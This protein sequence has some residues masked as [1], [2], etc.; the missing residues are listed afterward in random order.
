MYA[1]PARLQQVLWNLIKNAVKFT[2]RGGRIAIRSHHNA[3]GRITI[4]VSDTGIGIESHTL[5]VIFNAFEQGGSA[6]TRRF[7]G[8]GLGLAIS[9]KLIESH[10]G[11]STA[12]SEGKDR[13]ATFTISLPLG[14]R[15]PAPRAQ[16]PDPEPTNSAA[17]GTRILLVEDHLST[18]QVMARL[19]KALHFEVTVAHSVTTALQCAAQETFDLLISDLGL[20][21]AS[22]YDL[23]RQIQE[24][25][26]L[27]GIAL[28]GYGMEEDIKKSEEAGFSEHLIKPVD[29]QHLEAAIHRL[30]P[31]N[32]KAEPVA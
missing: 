20:P 14:P 30:V 3:S 21:D 6:T 24:R 19:L 16:C 29:L 2:P 31:A 27:K 9:R 11:S 8:L 5:A 18:A 26:N 12:E 1:D 22:G 28:S 17:Q 7:G 25:H 23:M 4:Q 32:E 13:G 15:A 10:G